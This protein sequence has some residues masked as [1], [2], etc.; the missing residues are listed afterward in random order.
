MYNA[1]KGG[2]TPDETELLE[3]L[4]STVRE[5]LERD[6]LGKTHLIEYTESDVIAVTLLYAHILGNRLIHHL[7]REKTGIGLANELAQHYASIINEVTL[8]MGRV[9][10][11]VYYKGRD[12]EQ[13]K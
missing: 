7:T 5:C 12:K 10:T 8:G 4:H 13:K 3:G 9:D 11:S 2:I 6:R 1:A